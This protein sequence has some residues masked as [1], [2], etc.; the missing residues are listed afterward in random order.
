MIALIFDTETTGLVNNRSLPLD[1]LPE[2]IE[3]C[4]F[5]VNLETGKIL[6][7]YETLVKP[8]VFPM[9]AQTIKETKTKLT[10]GMLEK[11]KTF[12][13]LA[14][15]IVKIIEDAPLLIAHN[16]SFDKEMCDIEMERLGQSIKWPPVRCTVEQSVFVK[17][18]RLNL[19]KLH[20]ELF[21][22]EFEDAHRAR[23]DV[24]ALTRCAIEMF[25]RGWL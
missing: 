2:I 17:G 11:A 19:T 16:V 6:K 1:R 5:L 3:W 7:E 20:A 13:D 24:A 21:G 18:K 25:R 23:N 15:K 14:P 4:S 9:S 22:T 8:T 10:N 12:K